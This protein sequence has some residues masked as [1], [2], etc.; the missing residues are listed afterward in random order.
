MINAA[1]FFSLN[2]QDCKIQGALRSA[3]LPGYKCASLREQR[4]QGS[5][6]DANCRKLPCDEMHFLQ[7]YIVATH[8]KTLSNKKEIS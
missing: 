2:L 7:C 6:G 3:L 4:L 5:R 1:Q 8:C